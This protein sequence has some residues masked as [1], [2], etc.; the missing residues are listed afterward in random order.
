ML[1]IITSFAQ[2]I[3][4]RK[5]FRRRKS[6]KINPTPYLGCA[7]STVVRSQNSTIRTLVI[8][9]AYPFCISPLLPHPEKTAKNVHFLFELFGFQKHLEIIIGLLSHKR[10]HLVPLLGV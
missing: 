6:L 10:T 5:V 2:R 8:V 9:S 1:L 4:N 7:L 3:L